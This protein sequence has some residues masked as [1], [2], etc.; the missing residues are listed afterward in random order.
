MR[1]SIR[2]CIPRVGYLFSFVAEFLY[3]A[4]LQTACIFPIGP[5]FMGLMCAHFQWRIG[6][7]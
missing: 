2:Q 1:Y 6:F 5:L 7:L 4:I 3:S